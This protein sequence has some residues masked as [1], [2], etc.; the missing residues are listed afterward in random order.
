MRINDLIKRCRIG[1]TVEI[2]D[3][4]AL[5]HRTSEQI[6]IMKQ[7][8]ANGANVRAPDGKVITPNEADTFLSGMLTRKRDAPVN[9]PEP[10]NKISDKERKRVLKYW[11]RKDLSNK[12]V[13]SLAGYN[14]TTLWRWFAG[15]YPR[16]RKAGRPKSN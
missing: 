2:D 13:A 8:F 10:W 9:I 14:Y 12:Q 6:E 11:R 15:E 1:S 4:R 5:A 7:I 16:K 3:V